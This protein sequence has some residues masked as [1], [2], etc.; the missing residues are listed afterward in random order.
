MISSILA[1]ALAATPASTVPA[2][3]A[4]SPALD[5]WAVQFDLPS[6]ITGRTYRI[7]VTKLLGP[8]PKA[9]WP[10]V[11]VL[12]A[13][14]TFPSLAAQMMMRTAGGDSG[15]LLVGAAYPNAL[16]TMTLRNRHLTPSQ[17]P[18]SRP[19]R[20][21]PQRLRQ[22]QGRGLRRRRGLSPH[23]GGAPAPDRRRL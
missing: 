22:A 23:D 16:A 15:A 5:P 4:T 9:G 19:R 8:T 10:V 1:L 14:V 17:H 7:Y 21:W 3:F 13:D 12:D 6:A 11:Y 20:R 2:T 18:R